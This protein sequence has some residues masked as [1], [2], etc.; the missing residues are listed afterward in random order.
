V[1]NNFAEGLDRKLGFRE[2]YRIALIGA[3]PDVVDYFSKEFKHIEF[4]TTLRGGFDIVVF[5]AT[6]NSELEKR[7]TTLTRSLRSKG[8]LWI[9][10]PKKTSRIVTDLNFDIVQE[11]GLAQSLVDTKACSIS[12]IWSSLRFTERRTVDTSTLASA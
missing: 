10:W 12:E 3:G 1:G 4:S 6:R 7:I 11:T 9:A 5:F 8:A 2:G